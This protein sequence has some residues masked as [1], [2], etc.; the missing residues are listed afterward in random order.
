VL[1]ILNPIAASDPLFAT[2]CRQGATVRY[3][4]DLA[5]DHVVLAITGAPAAVEFLAARFAGEPA[6]D[7]CA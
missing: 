7:D 6:P 4:R 3:H 1:D 5:S 2:Y